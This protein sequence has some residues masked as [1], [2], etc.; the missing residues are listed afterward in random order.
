[1]VSG[2]VSAQ[3]ALWDNGTEVNETLGE[4]ANQGPRQESPD[5]GEVENGT[6]QLAGSDFPNAPDVMR[7]MLTP[8]DNNQIH[9]RVENLTGDAPVPTPIS[10]LVYVVHN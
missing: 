4:G 2:D 5:A 9:V 10:P 3:I 8:G 6:V 7:V 1:P